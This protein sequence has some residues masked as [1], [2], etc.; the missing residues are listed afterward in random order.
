MPFWGGFLVLAEPRFLRFGLAYLR[1]FCGALFFWLFRP[2]KRMGGTHDGERIFPYFYSHG[3]EIPLCP[4]GMIQYPRGSFCF[5]CI[6]G[7]GG[8]R[9]E[10]KNTTRYPVPREEGR[11]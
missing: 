8:C 1:F 5:L 9:K 6:D 4:E 10:I 11:S 7:R 3:R 2:M